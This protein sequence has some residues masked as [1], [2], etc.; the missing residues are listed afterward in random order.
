MSDEQSE[1]KLY[2]SNKITKANTVICTFFNIYKCK[3]DIKTWE[4]FPGDVKWFPKDR[5]CMPGRGC[6]QDVQWTRGKSFT[7]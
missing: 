5:L 4:Q 2:K 6:R 3:K 7:K 1:Q